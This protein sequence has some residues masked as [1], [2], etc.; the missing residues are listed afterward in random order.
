MVVAIVIAPCLEAVLAALVLGLP[1]LLVMAGETAI[2]ALL[3][4]MGFVVSAS[5]H[6]LPGMRLKTKLV[7]R[8]ARA[9]ERGPAKHQHTDRRCYHSAIH[10]RLLVTHESGVEYRL[11]GGC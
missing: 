4:Q 11:R 9:G 7:A 8:A 10:H 3:A 2:V 6:A 1:P 5:I